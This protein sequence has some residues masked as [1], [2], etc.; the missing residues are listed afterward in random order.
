MKNTAKPGAVTKTETK[1]SAPESNRKIKTGKKVDT[2]AVKA[3][4]IISSSYEPEGEVLGEEESDRESDRA[5]ES[6]DWRSRSQRP[7][8]RRRR[9]SVADDPRYG[10]MSDSEWAGSSHNPANKRK[11]R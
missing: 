2:L 9:P 5:R 4:K 8:I 10:S 11:R 7:P 1:P 3:N 6:G